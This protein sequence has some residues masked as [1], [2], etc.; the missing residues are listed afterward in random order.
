MPGWIT[1]NT[2]MF[3]QDAYMAKN[4]LEAEEVQVFLKDEFSVQVNNFYSNALG[5]VKLQ[6]W[7]EDKEK[8][9]EILKEAGFLSNESDIKSKNDKKEI[10]P[11]K[12]STIC[13]YCDSPEVSPE[14]RL[15][16]LFAITYIVG[17][18]LPFARSTYHCFDCGKEW[19]VN[20][21]SLK[22]H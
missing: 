2:Y 8:A 4:V 3:P 5:G 16:P 11:D 19:K 17:V 14:K 1:I 10:F 7:K 15:G 6:V 12:F 20:P 9:L 18:P 13:P 22:G 21:K